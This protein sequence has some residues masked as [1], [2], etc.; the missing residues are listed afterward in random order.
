MKIKKYENFVSEDLVSA[1]P[2]VKPANPDVK[3]DTKRPSKPG[4]IRRE[5]QSPIPAPS[6]ARL[7]RATA[8]DVANKFIELMGNNGEDI[9]KY[10][11]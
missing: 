8:E 2:T 4:P 11:N 10:I 3:P 1:Q 9:K 7:K 5:R 6:K